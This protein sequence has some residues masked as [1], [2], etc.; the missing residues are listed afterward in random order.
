MAPVVAP[1]VVGRVCFVVYSR[2]LNLKTTKGKAKEAAL[3]TF[4]S[5][6]PIIKN[7]ALLLKET[8]LI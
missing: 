5:V 1:D 7:D 4:L 8:T 3:K 6:T 2:L